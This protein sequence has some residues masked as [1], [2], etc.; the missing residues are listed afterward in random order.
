M[1]NIAS[2]I[3]T[4][5]IIE[6]VQAYLHVVDH[7]LNKTIA[8]KNNS[9]EREKISLLRPPFYQHW[10]Q[11]FQITSPTCVHV[12]CSTGIDYEY[13]VLQVV[14]I[15][16]KTSGGRPYLWKSLSIW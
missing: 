2:G 13:W 6:L 14:G 16:Q 8:V 10:A 7:A 9:L 4:M 1:F 15:S 12:T 11:S 3:N 5:E